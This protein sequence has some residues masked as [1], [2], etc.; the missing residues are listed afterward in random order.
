MARSQKLKSA[1]ATGKTHLAVQENAPAEISTTCLTWTHWTKDHT[2]SLIKFLAS[3]RSEAGDG[4]NFKIGVF[5]A[6]TAHFLEPP[7]GVPKEGWVP[8]V[9]RDSRAC[10]N[11]WAAHKIILD[12]KAQSGFSWDNELGAGID[13]TSEAVWAAYV[14]KRP[15]AAPFCNRGWPHFDEIND[16]LSTTASKGTHAFHAALEESREQSPDLDFLN[17]EGLL[18]PEPEHAKNLSQDVQDTLDES[19][20]DEDFIPWEKTPPRQSHTPAPLLNSTSGPA[21]KRH[22]ASGAAALFAIADQFS[23]FTDAFH[24]SSQAQP[25]SLTPSPIQRQ[26]AMQHAQNVETHLTGD[27]MAALIEAFQTDFINRKITQ[28]NSR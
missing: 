3:H 23:D 9:A 8:P 1:A 4:M 7:K 25:S 18:Q 24:S 28:I 10:K 5:Q 20:D 17:E 26:C 6:V 21:S 22:R 16:L 12:I 11:K 14:K 15:D 2:S 27:E 13:S 19:G